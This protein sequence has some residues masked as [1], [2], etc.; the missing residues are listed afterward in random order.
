MPQFDSQIT[1]TKDGKGQIS[2]QF[3]RYDR[4]NEPL[5]EADY[6]KVCTIVNNYICGNFEDC[7]IKTG[8]EI[9]W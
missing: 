5:T 4:P 1:V 9:K 7:T 3:V 2:L 8:K 6:A